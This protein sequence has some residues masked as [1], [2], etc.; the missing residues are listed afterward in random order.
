MNIPERPRFTG[1]FFFAIG[2]AE[3]QKQWDD[4]F[5]NLT[6]E[7][8]I[9]LMKLGAKIVH[10]TFYSG[11]YIIMIGDETIDENGMTLH[12]FW[13][14]RNTPVFETGWSVFVSP[15]K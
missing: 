8:A 1:D 3:R 9:D 6:K 5:A 2:L 14:I 4:A 11:E 15:E 12:D 7:K 13:E 10:P